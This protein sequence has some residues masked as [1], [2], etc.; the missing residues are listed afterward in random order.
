M[1]T[2]IYVDVLLVINFMVNFILLRITALFIRRQPVFWRL[3]LAAVLGA[4]GALIIFVPV[5]NRA[6]L[7]GFKLLLTV[8][9]SV[10]AFGCKSA[11]RLLLSVFCLFTVSLLTSG[12]LLLVTVTM[13]PRGVLVSKGAVYFDIGAAA[14]IGCCIAAYFIAGGLVGLLA[15][16]SPK[17]A[18]CEITVLHAGAVS[19]FPALIDTGSALVEPFSHCPVI[20]CEERAL[21]SAMPQ[22]LKNFSLTETPA[23]GL[24][25]VPYKTLNSSGLLPAFM[26]DTLLVRLQGEDARK[27]GDCYIAVLNRPLGSDDYRAVCNPQMISYKEQKVGA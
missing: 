27:A 4:F 6:V 19:V 16:G 14:L 9:M 3:C 21:G 8:V 1:P 11:K 22:V 15:R 12:L 7:L 24:R 17:G 26:P 2:V 25:L 5:Y 23:Q 10:A 13:R 20:V 18:L